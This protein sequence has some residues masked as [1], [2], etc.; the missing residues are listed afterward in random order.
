MVRLF[1]DRVRDNV[2]RRFLSVWSQPIGAE[3]ICAGAVGNASRFTS[4]ARTA[5][6]IGRFGCGV[7]AL[8]EGWPGNP[9]SEGASPYQLKR[10]LEPSKTSSGVAYNSLRDKNHLPIEAHQVSDLAHL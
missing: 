6:C 7:H 10:R 5:I 3:I 4:A 2:S 1:F 9:G 8:S